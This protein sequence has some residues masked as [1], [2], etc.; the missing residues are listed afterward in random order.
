MTGNQDDSRL[1]D[2]LGVPPGNDPEQIRRELADRLSGEGDENLRPLA[3]SLLKDDERL[4][5][6]ALLRRPPT[7]PPTTLSP[8]E[9]PRPVHRGPGF[10]Y[11]LIREL[12]DG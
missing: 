12:P 1:L 2:E 11:R 5:R 7:P 4:H 8:L 10:W 9:P 3:G 6:L